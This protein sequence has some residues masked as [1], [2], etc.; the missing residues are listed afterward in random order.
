MTTQQAHLSLRV[1]DRSQAALD[2]FTKR[3]RAQ[4][5]SIEK[6]R[7]STH[8]YNQTI[9]VT[10]GNMRSMR[11]SMQ[12]MGYQVQDIA[13]QLQGGTNALQVFTQQ[14]SQMAGAFGPGGIVIGALLAVGGA[15]AG[16]VA[17]QLMKNRDLMKEL[18]RVGEQLGGTF[19]DLESDSL[20]L[21]N[22]MREL[23]EANRLA[24]SVEIQRDIID[25]REQ[26]SLLDEQFEELANNSP[27]DDKQTDAFLDAL[28]DIDGYLS[29]F[30]DATIDPVGTEQALLE[31][32]N[33][34]VRNL[35]GELGITT[36]EADRLFRAMNR[37]KDDEITASEFQ[38][39][40]D[41]VS[42][43]NEKMVQF[44]SNL[45]EVTMESTNAAARLREL[46]GILGGETPEFEEP[47]GGGGGG[48]DLRWPT[49]MF[50]EMN[51][52]RF[53][54]Q[55][56]EEAFTEFM[57][58]QN[59]IQAEIA[60]NMY[61]GR[62]EAHYE[63]LQRQ[64]NAYLE[65]QAAITQSNAE[66]AEKEKQMLEER[67]AAYQNLFTTAFDT[68]AS[69]ARDRHQMDVDALRN[70]EG[71]T[72][73]E[74]AARERAARK[75]FEAQQKWAAGAV[76]ANTGV[77]IMKALATEDP[78]TKWASVAAITATGLGQLN[79]IRTASYNGGGSISGGGGGAEPPAPV[80]NSTT[81]NQ[82]ANIY[83]TGNPSRQDIVDAMKEIF[84]EDN[85]LFESDSQQAQVIRS[86]Q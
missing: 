49:A 55:E 60:A 53:V 37:F 82:Q 72:E 52:R 57:R 79:S 8:R 1:T 42:D 34:E 74:I 7:G 77:A 46:Q 83:F 29:G 4:T 54:Q 75:S 50:D 12:M 33:Q 71:L 10:G 80:N 20:E 40:V 61:K 36:D 39:T 73:K 32:Y 22:Q 45:R 47:E 68:F 21:T 31:G 59:A 23:Y 41:S 81:M 30:A 63:Q 70:T 78:F 19:A 27:V 38:N 11:G 65:Y 44:A 76:I 28:K 9:G 56:E 69:F 85:V 86:G 51:K 64:K 35:S 66:A 24:F 58:E 67:K 2:G 26:L 15:L 3:V 62:A 43:G 17:P 13:V 14:G 16:V 84:S 5:T 6:L 18:E 25:L 48:G